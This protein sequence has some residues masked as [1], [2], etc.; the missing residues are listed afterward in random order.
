MDDRAVGRALLVTKR[1][2][3]PGET[4][5]SGQV[6]AA[7]VNPPQHPRRPHQSH[8]PQHP[9]GRSTPPAAPV[10]PAAAAHPPHQSTAATPPSAHHSTAAAAH[11]VPAALA[12]SD[13][14][15]PPGGRRV[16]WETCVLFRSV[17]RISSYL[18]SRR[19]YTSRQWRRCPDPTPR[20]ERAGA[21]FCRWL[22]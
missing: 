16:R 7:P 12:A 22:R 2:S 10:P 19:L 21:S 3:D 8:Q 13:L 5:S 17:F 1:Q 6:P 20:F 15:C 4:M 11:P 14:R 9:T 18:S